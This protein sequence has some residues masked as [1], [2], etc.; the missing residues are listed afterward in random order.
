MDRKTRSLNA[1]IGESIDTHV[2]GILPFGLATN[3]SK[4]FL[5]FEHEEAIWDVCKEEFISHFYDLFAKQ[6]REVFQERKKTQRI[7]TFAKGKMQTVQK[8]LPS[9]TQTE[10]NLFFID[11]LDD[12]N[13][14]R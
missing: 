13:I 12:A 11:G 10:I 6:L 14:K 8:L 2:I 4:W 1:A 7:E 5:D 3:A 9:F